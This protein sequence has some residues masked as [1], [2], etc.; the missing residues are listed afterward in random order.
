MTIIMLEE[1][2]NFRAFSLDRP[3]PR[4]Q[5]AS[6]GGMNSIAYRPGGIENR[7]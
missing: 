4:S 1:N 6:S 5:A 3:P 7:A 2:E